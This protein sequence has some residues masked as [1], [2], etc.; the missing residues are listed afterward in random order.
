VQGVSVI[1]LPESSIGSADQNW[2]TRFGA[3]NA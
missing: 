2:R 1:E 3:Q